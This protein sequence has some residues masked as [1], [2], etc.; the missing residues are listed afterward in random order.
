M[1]RIIAIVVLFFLQCHADL[2]PVM[3]GLEE[4]KFGGVWYGVAAASNCKQFL[5]MK[6]NNMPAPINIYSL[7][8]GHLKSST[9][10]Q[11]DK[12]CQQMDIDMTTVEKGHYKGKM[13]QGDFETIIVATDYDVFL[14]EF[15]KN[16]MG[17]E[18][19]VTVKLFGRKY[20]LPEDKIKHFREHIE[21]VGLKE[22]QY[23][24]FHTKATCVPK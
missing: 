16:Q 23:I 18:A 10:F 13:Q 7:N 2:P 17:A 4:N 9:S 22:E 1:I 3:K 15:T 6:S 11:T 19:C 5:Q 8:N 14:M 21:K 12:G 20:T 24:Q